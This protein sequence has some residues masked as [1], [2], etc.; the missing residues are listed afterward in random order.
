MTYKVLLYEDAVKMLNSIPPPAKERITKGLKVL[1]DNPYFNRPGADIKKLK[2]TKGR[3][4]AYRLR[5]GDYRA[6]YDVSESE[7]V[8]RVTRIIHR[9]EDYNWLD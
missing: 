9:S 1:E 8:V 2:G 5:I 6:I 3:Q 4:E 7:K